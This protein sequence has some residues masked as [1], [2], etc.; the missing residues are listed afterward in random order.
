M[1]R[2]GGAPVN[3]RIV[4]AQTSAAEAAKRMKAL[5]GL[6][7]EAL[8]SKPRQLLDAVLAW[9]DSL[10]NMVDLIARFATYRAAVD[11]GINGTDAARLALDSSL[12]VVRRG[13]HAQ[14]GPYVQEPQDR[15]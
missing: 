5:K 3:V 11:L 9:T 13:E 12:N 15:D 14:A 6:S 7:A 1:L 10:A 2:N 8:A 4:D